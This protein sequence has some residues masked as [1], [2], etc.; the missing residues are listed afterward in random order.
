[1]RNGME[2]DKEAGS[3]GPAGGSR[4]KSPFPEPRTLAMSRG[5]DTDSDSDESDGNA[6]TFRGTRLT[7]KLS[8]WLQN[9]H[10]LHRLWSLSTQVHAHQA[11]LRLLLLAAP[12]GLLRLCMQHSKHLNTFNGM[13]QNFRGTHDEF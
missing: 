2:A 1:M 12:S 6:E 10:L 5:D 13:S 7:L 11:C 4:S 9:A 8:I 3:A